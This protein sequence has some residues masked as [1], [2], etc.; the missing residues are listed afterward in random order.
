MNASN[1]DVRHS[2][3]LTGCVAYDRDHPEML[4]ALAEGKFKG[5]EQLITRRIP[6]ED[7]VEKGVK[8]LINEKDEHGELCPSASTFVC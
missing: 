4:K 5:L 1:T 2:L 8:A 3:C 7:F 6:L